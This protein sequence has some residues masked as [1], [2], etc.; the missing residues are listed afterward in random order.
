[1]FAISARRVI[2]KPYHILTNRRLIFFFWILAILVYFISPLSSLWNHNTL[3]IFFTNL[4]GLSSFLFIC[5]YAI[6]MVIGFPTVIY[7][8]AGGAVFGFYWGVMYS[9]IGATIGTM[10]GFWLSRYLLRHWA[11]QNLGRHPI[12]RKFRHG[13][14]AQGL[15]FVIIVRLIPVTPFNLEN[16]LFGLTLINWQPYLLGTIL[17]II[18]GTFGYTWLGT[19]GAKALEV[20]NPVSLI[21]AISFLL[22][23]AIIPLLISRLRQL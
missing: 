7:T 3:A 11:E 21:F 9:L 8:V 16:Y 23:L 15:L 22:A 10:G 18:P 12:L 4:G 14:S 2:M 13:I 20:G 17:G 19:S 6:S 1:M 5:L